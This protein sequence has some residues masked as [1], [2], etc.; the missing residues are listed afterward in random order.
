MKNKVV[1]SPILVFVISVGMT[2]F[3]VLTL[4]NSERENAI[5]RHRAEAVQLVELLQTMIDQDINL[6]GSVANFFYS[7]DENEWNKFP[8]FA[9]GTL[10]HQSHIIALQWMQRVAPEELIAHMEEIQRRYPEAIPYTTENHSL[11]YKKYHTGDYVYIA[12][13]IYPLTNENREVIGFF[14][15]KDQ[16]LQILQSLKLNRKPYLSDKQVLLQSD[17]YNRGQADGFLIYYPVFE[18]TNQELKGIVISAIRSQAYLEEVINHYLELDKIAIKIVDGKIQS[19]DEQVFYQSKNWDTPAELEFT[20]Y[21]YFTNR[22]WQVRFRYQQLLSDDTDSRLVMIGMLGG[23]GS[24]LI[25]AI[26]GTVTVSRVHL[27]RDLT[28]RSYELEYQLNHD[29]QTHALSRKAFYYECD[30]RISNADIFSLIIFDV[31]RFQSVNDRIGRHNGDNALIHIVDI[32]FD[33]LEKGDQ[34]YRVGGDEFAILCDKKHPVELKQYMEKIRTEV[35]LNPWGQASPLY[36]TISLGGAIWKGG[37]I[38]RIEHRADNA[39]YK[40]KENGGNESRVS[41][42]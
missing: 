29:H 18:P 26:V 28:K 14:P 11:L 27:E 4:D 2:V 13:D 16:F 33:I 31:D 9:Q 12:S 7:V 30:K 25:T 21:L 6:T 8:H 3:T 39:L 34:I 1:W 15:A 17:L 36:L 19:S 10:E 23:L 24:L 35:E 5:S 20:H 32:V 42:G 37:D 40:S 41:V 38:D 22:N